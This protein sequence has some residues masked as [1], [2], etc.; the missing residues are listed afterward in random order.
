MEMHLVVG[1]PIVNI[2]NNNFYNSE[3]IS[4]SGDQKYNIQNLWKLNPE[5]IE[6]TYKLSDKSALKNK[7]TDGTDLGIIS[8]K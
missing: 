8:K 6:G 3:A 2:F 1:E 4:I 7:G 5:F